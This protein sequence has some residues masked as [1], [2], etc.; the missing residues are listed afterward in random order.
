MSRWRCGSDRRTAEKF[1]PRRNGMISAL[2]HR[3][4][5][6]SREFAQ[7][8][9]PA[10][11]E[12]SRSR[13]AGMARTARGRAVARAVFP[14]GLYLARAHRG[15]CLPEQGRHLRFLVQGLR[16]DHARDRSRSQASGRQDRLHRRASY[17]GFCDDAPS[18]CA[19]DRARPDAL[20]IPLILPTIV[21]RAFMQIVPSAALTGAASNAS[22]RNPGKRAL[23]TAKALVRYRQDER[24]RA[25]ARTLSAQYRARRTGR[26]RRPDT[27]IPA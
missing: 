12:V 5:P 24:A 18:A 10:L 13:G 8:P 6:L 2:G 20:A 27:T 23:S 7:L 1:P 14:S 16:R 21:K 11:P 26:G 15:Y 25:R 4:N 22:R 3:T 17:L 19:Y 9:Q